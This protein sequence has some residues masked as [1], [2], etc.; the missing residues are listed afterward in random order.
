MKN[1]KGL[2][3]F[4]AIVLLIGV[5][6]FCWWIFFGRFEDFT[7]DAYVNGNQVRLTSQVSGFVSAVYCNETEYVKQ[8]QVLVELD[9]T[10]KEIAYHSSLASLGSAVR[11][12]T[13]MFENVYTLAAIVKEREALLVKAEIDFHDREAVIASGA[14]S[15]EDFI[16]AKTNLEASLSSLEAARFNLRKAISLVEN[17]TVRTHPHVKSAIEKVKHGY[18]NLNRCVIK[19]PASGLVAQRTV[20]VGESITTATPLLAIVPLNQ[21]WVNANFKEIHMKHIRIGQEVSMTSDFYGSSV[22]YR[23]RV[24]GIAGGTGAVFSPLPP[25]NATGN[26]IKIVQR[27]PVR[28]S[29]PEQVLMKY[30]L[31]LG[32]SMNV[33]VSV[34]DVEGR[35]VPEPITAKKP[36]YETKVF[37]EQEEGVDVVIEK[38][39]KENESFVG[40]ISEEVKL[41]GTKRR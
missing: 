36:I 32:L 34:K 6:V 24:L 15:M 8:G 22:V 19:A 39:L 25:Q 37:S 18:V 5:I 26:W 3:I 12:V 30:P 10:D 35:K 7:R 33:T 40:M 11:S 14:V 38:V 1:K 4:S 13:Q 9:K 28:V 16:N 31:R 27:V 21:I 23:G 29:L 17:T 20:Q 2:I 41:L